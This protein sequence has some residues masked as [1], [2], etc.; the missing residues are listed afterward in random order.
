MKFEAGGVANAKLNTGARQLLNYLKQCELPTALL[1]RN[2]RK[3]VDGVCRKLKLKFD[4]VFTREDGPHKPDPAPIR[5]IA[6]AWKMRRSELLMI[7]DYKWDVLCAHNAG[8]ACALLLDGKELP[9]WANEA[10]YVIR[11]LREV[12]KIIETS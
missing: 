5:Q 2:S 6:R 11:R 10:E 12:V 8:I 1:T 7:G 4:L 3:S 9:E